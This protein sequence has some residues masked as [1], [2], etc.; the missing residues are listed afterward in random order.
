VLLLS[1]P[2]APQTVKLDGPIENDT[3][4]QTGQRIA[5][6]QNQRYVKLDA[7]RKAKKTSELVDVAKQRVTE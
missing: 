6:T 1:A 5:F 7:I 3:E 2:D 4:S